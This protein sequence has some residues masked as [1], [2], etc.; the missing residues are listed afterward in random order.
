LQINKAQLVKA[1]SNSILCPS[2]LCIEVSKKGK[3]CGYSVDCIKCWSEVFENES[4]IELIGG[5][6]ECQK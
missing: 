4:H 5:I 1:F 6:E 3:T 2:D